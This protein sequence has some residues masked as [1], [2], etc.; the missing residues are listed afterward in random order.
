MIEEMMAVAISG[1][2]GERVAAIVT[3]VSGGH[4][5]I[6]YPKPKRVHAEPRIDGLAL[7]TVRDGITDSKGIGRCGKRELDIIPRTF[8]HD[9]PPTGCFRSESCK[10]TVGSDDAAMG[11][12]VLRLILH[13]F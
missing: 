4:C 5:E 1:M 2:L 6:G 10:G 3:T 12:T 11:G 9:R 8:K 7:R 13:K